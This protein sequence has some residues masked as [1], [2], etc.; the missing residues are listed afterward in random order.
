MQPIAI[1]KAVSSI[2]TKS[3]QDGPFYGIDNQVNF[4]SIDI[5]WFVYQLLWIIDFIDLKPLDHNFVTA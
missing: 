1:P 2:F 3:K 5:F 4:N